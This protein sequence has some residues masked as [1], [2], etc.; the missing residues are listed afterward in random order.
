MKR[1]LN[2][3]A[4]SRFDELLEKCLREGPQIVTKHGGEIAVLVPMAH[5]RASYSGLPAR[6]R[7][8]CFC[9]TRR[10]QSSRQGRAP[11]VVVQRRCRR[12]GFLLPAHPLKLPPVLRLERRDHIV[13]LRGQRDIVEP[14]E[15]AAPAQRM[16]AESV[17][18]TVD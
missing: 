11:G 1:W 17:L 8:S 16:N 14:F 6:H 18:T 3:G 2:H 9:P 13:E 12:I 4:S 10:E 5:S 7:R 15:Q